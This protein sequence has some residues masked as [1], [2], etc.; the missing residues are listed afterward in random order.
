MWAAIFFHSALKVGVEPV[1][2][3][4]AK[5]RLSKHA[6]LTGAPRPG[7][8]LMTPSGSPASRRMLNTCQLASMLVPEGFQST[9]LPICAGVDGR[10]EPM[11]KKLKGVM[12]STKP[13]SGRYSMRFHVV[14]LCSGGCAA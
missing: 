9:T 10:L 11:A 4:P 13:S 1:K 12:A 2:W 6:S 5:S 14:G 3:S 8:K 7:K